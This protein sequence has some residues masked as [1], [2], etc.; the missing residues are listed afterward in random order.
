[1]WGDE[2]Q[3]TTT[4]T[5]KED[6]V[7]VSRI[8][9]PHTRVNEGALFCLCVTHAKH[10]APLTC[11]RE[12]RRSNLTVN[13]SS[14]IKSSGDYLSRLTT[15]PS[16]DFI[17]FHHVSFTSIYRF[18]SSTT[19]A[20]VEW[21]QHSFLFHAQRNSQVVWRKEGFRFHCP[22]RRD[23]GCL[24]TSISHPCRRLSIFSGK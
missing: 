5:T 20:G 17:S 24:C 10:T 16:L 19:E 21:Y 13:P 9:P 3:Q 4:T 22:W 12:Q 6:K 2:S 15:I 14:H 23:R 7:S 11:H 8:P 18:S 1:V